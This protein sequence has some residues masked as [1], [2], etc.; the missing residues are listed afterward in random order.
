MTPG[1]GGTARSIGAQISALARERPDQDC[2]IFY[3]LSRKPV[4]ITWREFDEQTN[5]VARLLQQDGALKGG[6]VVIGLDNCIEH[7]LAQFGAWKIGCLVVPLAA[8]LPPFERDQVL[9]VSEASV[10]V[11]DWPD[12]DIEATLIPSASM[13]DR[14]VSAAP[15]PDV[16]PHPGKAIA[17]GGSTG[18]PKIIIDPG[19]LTSVCPGLATIAEMAGFMPFQ[20]QLIAGPLF[21]NSP[22]TWGSL[23]GL[24]SGQT[25]VVMERFRADLAVDLIER[26]RVNWMVMVPTMM[27]RILLLDDIKTRDF[28]SLTGM[29]HTG[30]PCPIQVKRDWLA[31]VGAEK[32]LEGFGA[33][34]AVGGCFIRGDQWLERPG[35]VGRPLDCDLKVLDEAG[36]EVPPRVVGEIFMRP[37]VGEPTYIYRG[38]PPARST[39]DGFISVGDMGS[40]DQEG[41]VF[42]ADRRA[43]LIIT[44]GANVY[45]AEVEAALLEHPGVGDTAVVGLP[46]PDLG[47]RVHAVIQPP[48]GGTPPTDTDLRAHC[49]ERLTGEKR[50]RSYSYVEVLPRNEFGKIRRSALRDELAAIAPA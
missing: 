38:S 47:Q 15:L 16:V 18:R 8:G 7:Y 37:H 20:V 30:A 40:V 42:L 4:S 3:S 39:S 45:P 1:E 34:E 26:H 24:P 48:D 17:S 12:I 41:Y 5:R 6:T 25:L 21:H 2:I 11:A 36:G 19:P 44:G 27:R 49:A 29:F 9:A 31:L 33:T 50:P 13:W 35:T 23:L 43:D 46:D 32:V 14:T 28:S 10:V 22:F